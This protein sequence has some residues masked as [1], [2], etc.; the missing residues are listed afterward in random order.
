[1]KKNAFLLLLRDESEQAV[2]LAQQLDSLAF[3]IFV[4]VDGKSKSKLGRIRKACKFSEVIYVPRVT[5]G[6][7]GYSMVK[8]EISLMKTAKDLPTE[9][10]YYHLISESDLPIWT[11]ERIANFF[12][13]ADREYVEIESV[14]ET[15]NIN[16]I[17]YFY[18]LQEKVGKKHNFFWTLQKI[19]V[20]A[21]KIIRINRISNI[22]EQIVIAKGSQWFSITDEFVEYVLE[23]STLIDDVFKLSR[24]PD[25]LFI[26]TIL[27]NSPFK[28]R[29]SNVVD[30]NLRFIIWNGKNS[31]QVLTSPDYEKITSS[32][33]MMARKINCSVGSQ[34]LARRIYSD[35]E[36]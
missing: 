36:Q 27:V 8:A 11:N 7:A 9:Y 28:N 33:K 26:Q 35:R 2:R 31:P 29:I 3:D 6:W 30:S 34:S 13:D 4:H 17:K 1:M 15:V 21:E 32:N 20:L 25:E 12:S 19:F 22:D 23:H 10:K 5:V 24:A 16:R 18:P 14:N